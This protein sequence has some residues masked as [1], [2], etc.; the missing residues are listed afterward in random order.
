MFRSVYQDTVDEQLCSG[1][2]L[3]ERNMSSTLKNKITAVLPGMMVF[4]TPCLAQVT[5]RGEN[6]DRS[7]H[8]LEA[9]L[10]ADEEITPWQVDTSPV[11]YE[12]DDLFDYINGGAE[13]YHEYGFVQVLTQDYANVDVSLTVDIYE[14]KDAPAAFGIYSI[15]REPEQPAFDFGDGGS[16]FDY[17]VAFWQARY[18]VIITVST[19]SDALISDLERFAGSISRRIDRNAALPDIVGLLPQQALLPGSEGYLRGFLGLNT[20]LYLGQENVLGFDGE[21]VEG[22][23]ATYQTDQGNSGL[24]VLVYPDTSSASVIAEQ[25]DNL[26]KEKYTCLQDCSRFV[27]E[28]ARYYAVWPVDASVYICFKSTSPALVATIFG[29][30]SALQE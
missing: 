8:P 9:L 27:D 21:R 23:F 30:I 1:G 12:G 25:V 20:Q 3:N 18:Y 24:A 11:V 26:F 22:A 13:P 10:P 19:S 5:S 28:R 7:S 17:H 15:Q 4:L 14:M 16:L 29:Y 6:G 2:D